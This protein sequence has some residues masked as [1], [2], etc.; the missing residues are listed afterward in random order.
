[1]TLI[2]T[3]TPVINAL[4]RPDLFNNVDSPIYVKI[5]VTTYSVSSRILLT[6]VKLNHFLQARTVV[7]LSLLIATLGTEPLQ[8]VS[9]RTSVAINAKERA[10]G[11]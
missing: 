11:P 6:D 4:I 10:V 2:A 3:S 7:G 9:R 8:L 5:G 1:M